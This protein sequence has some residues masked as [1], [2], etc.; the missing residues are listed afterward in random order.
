ML[1]RSSQYINKMLNK[2]LV[3]NKCGAEMLLCCL[4]AVQCGPDVMK[5][6]TAVCM[7]PRTLTWRTGKFFDYD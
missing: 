3:P 5:D 6:C 2:L 7:A 1:L 4:S